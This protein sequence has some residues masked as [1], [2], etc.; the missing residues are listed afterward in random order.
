VSVLIVDLLELVDVDQHQTGR[1]LEQRA[2]L[3]GTRKL[4][5]EHTAVADS[6]ERVEVGLATGVLELFVEDIDALAE[7]ARQGELALMLLIEDLRKLLHGLERGCLEL[8]RRAADRRTE[9]VELTRGTRVRCDIAHDRL[10][11]PFEHEPDGVAQVADRARRGLT[12]VVHVVDDV[13]TE[14]GPIALGATD[15]ERA[16]RCRQNEDV[17]RPCLQ[18]IRGLGTGCGRLAERAQ[19]CR[20]GIKGRV[21]HPISARRLAVDQR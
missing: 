15:A 8:L 9:P 19:N 17:A 4:A 11:Q 20:D 10:R 5:L 12:V 3:H 16:R 18:L 13:T 7:V 6:C 2:D 21:R 1:L 14:A